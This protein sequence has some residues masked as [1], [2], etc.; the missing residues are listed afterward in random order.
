MVGGIRV[1]CLTQEVESNAVYIGSVAMIPISIL[2]VV[3]DYAKR[4]ISNYP[5]VQYA[6]RRSRFISS[7]QS[8]LPWS[9]QTARR[10]YYRCLGVLKD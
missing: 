4:R 9:S 6:R 3:N 1:R 7:Y 5:V 10:S 8:V 2:N